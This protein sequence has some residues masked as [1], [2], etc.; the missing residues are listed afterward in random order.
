MAGFLCALQ[1]NYFTV[2]FFFVPCKSIIL[3]SCFFGAVQIQYFTVMLCFFGAVQIKYFTVVPCFFVAVQIKYFTGNECEYR[4]SEYARVNPRDCRYWLSGNCLNPK[5]PFRHPPL[6]GLLGTQAAVTGGPSVSP[7][8]I[9]TASATHAP[10]NSSKQ[11]VPC[12]FFQKGLCLKGDR[13]AFLHGPPTP[14]SSTGNKVAAQVPV[15]SQGVENPCF[16][17][18]FVSNEK[19]TQERKTSQG[20]VAKSSGISEAKPASKIETAPQRNMFEWEKKVPPPAVGFDNEVSRFKTTS[21]PVTNG[22]TV[23]RPNRLHQA[24]VPDDHNFQSG[25]D[26]DEFL[27]ESSPGFDVL[28]ADELRNSD[29]YHG[30]DEFSK[31]RGQDERNLDSLNEYDLGH[32]GDYSLAADIDRERFRVP[33]GYESYDHLQEPY[34]WEQHRKPS[35]HVDRRTR[36]RSNSPEN[37]EVSDLRHHLSKRRKGNGLKSVVGHDYAHEGHGEEQSRRPFSRKDSLELPLNESFLGNRFRGRIKLPAN[38]GADHLERED[39][40]RFRNRLSS[41]R[42][43]ATHHLSPGEGRVHD[44]IRGRL[45]DDERRNSKDRLMGRELPGDR[46]D[47]AGPKSLSELKNGRNTENRE[48]QSLG[49]RR[50]LRDDRPQSEDDF[51]FEGPKPLS[52]ILKEKR[53]AGADADSGNGKS[54]DNKNQEVTNGQNPT[55]AANTQNGVLSETKEDVKNLPPNNEESSKLEVTDAAGGDNDGEY[56]E[57]MVYDEAGE[58]QYYEGDDQRDADYEYEQGEGDEGYYEYEQG[59][60]GENQEEDYMEEEDGDDFAKKIGVVHS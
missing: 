30:E 56:E 42:L 54:S 51:L 48:Q 32:S 16:K 40:G 57:G 5:C 10:Y 14:T 58:D 52:E 24:R 60:E 12:F 15:T 6:D 7:S 19:Y 45:Q 31:A 55:P 53:G 25:K 49:R 50:S 11:A 23:A 41:G 37:A 3:L 35:A 29:Y 38:G 46:S 1:I 17:K 26:S 18:P 2:V 34:A 22:P 44:R 27:R 33:Q 59:E 20:N 9:P 47:F 13:C 28:V 36:R 21:P 43:P 4:H 8:Q 39:R